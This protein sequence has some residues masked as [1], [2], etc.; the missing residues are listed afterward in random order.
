[1]TPA[2]AGWNCSGGG[3]IAS[4]VSLSRTF[5]RD[6]GSSTYGITAT[7][8]GASGGGVVFS[9]GSATCFGTITS[10]TTVTLNPPAYSGGAADPD[11][12]AVDVTAS[13]HTLSSAYTYYPAADAAPDFFEDASGSPD[14]AVYRNTDSALDTTY[15]GRVTS[16]S[17]ITHST[18]LAGVGI[19]TALKF[20]IVP[21][22]DGS[23]GC[24]AKVWNPT[25]N[26]NGSTRTKGIWLFHDLYVPAATVTEFAKSGQGGLVP[27]GT[28]QNKYLLYRVNGGQPP[29]GGPMLGGGA[30][31]GGQQLR[32][33]DDA[34]TGGNYLTNTGKTLADTTV[35]CVT[36]LRRDTSA[37]LGHIQQWFD[38][39]ILVNPAAHASYMS[40]STSAFYQFLL[41]GAYD[42]ITTSVVLYHAHIS[43]WHGC[44]V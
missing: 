12:T 40:D 33:Q 36:R 10:S 26:T 32:S 7:V 18:D 30:D 13:G 43:A 23:G 37:S 24:Y 28:C 34:T 44:P 35:E 25:G 20:T 31:F 9:F 17:H 8:T 38:G 22:G 16:G 42:E 5:G 27:G 14:G 29:N 6:D 11:G 21:A 2:L 19:P 15:G 41:G 1:M 39:Q 3:S 4:L